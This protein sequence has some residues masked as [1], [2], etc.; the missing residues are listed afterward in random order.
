MKLALIQQHATNDI[1]S[2]IQRGLDNID[3]AAKQGVELAV[4][5]ELAFT[6]FYP[7]Y[8]A[9]G[10]VRH[11]AEQVP[12]PTTEKFMAKAKEHNM[13]VVINLFELEDGKTYDSSPVIDADGTLLGTTQMVHVADYERFYE[14]SYYA[15]GTHG[16]MV[17]DTAVGKVGVAICYDRHYPEFMR[18]LGVNGAEVVV[19]PQAGTVG[20]W[21]KGLYEAEL[22]V[23]S[24]QNGYYC[25]LA[26]RV[27]IEDRLTFAGESFVTDPDG[28]ILAQSPSGEDHILITDI[29]LSNVKKSTARTMFFRD[30]RPDIYPLD[31]VNR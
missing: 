1:N 27:G 7:Q 22:Q 15:E 30:R 12:G 9:D 6:R 10:D 20:E 18:A 3:Q 31:D 28:K 16:A 5:A 11:L 4:F 23:A 14:K 2:N 29:D 19:I 17:Y 8:L 26:N 13:V 21:P 24:F 25:G